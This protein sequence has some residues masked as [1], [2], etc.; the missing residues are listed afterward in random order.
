MVNS[1]YGII[2]AMKALL[3]VTILLIFGGCVSQKQPSPTQD[4][5]LNAISSSSA[6]SSKEGFMQRALDDWL[7]NEWEEKTKTYQE[8]KHSDNTKLKNV[9][10]DIT[11]DKKE[12]QEGFLQH[13]VDKAL[14]Y[15]ARPKE[16]NQ[17]SL[18][19]ELEKMP[20]VGSGEKRR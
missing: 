1:E 19:K 14:Y 3:T 20:A 2:L 10:K 7:E 5:A 6:Q 8:Q 11:K 13:Y 16:N 9:K 12:S 18:V 15:N 4:P 17:S